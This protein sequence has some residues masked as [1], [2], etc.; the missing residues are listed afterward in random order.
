MNELITQ[1]NQAATVP[2][3]S[4]ALITV[5]DTLRHGLGQQADSSVALINDLLDSAPSG[6]AQKFL[7]SG[8]FRDPEVVSWVVSLIMSDSDP[9]ADGASVEREIAAIQK[10]MRNSG[11]DYWRGPNAERIQA[12]YRTLV[13]SR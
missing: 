2:A 12:R 9:I 1:S 3:A 10:M 4:D 8:I 6:V 13:A 11:S 7:K 5:D